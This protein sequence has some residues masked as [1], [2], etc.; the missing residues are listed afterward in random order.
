MQC[1]AAIAKL[2]DSRTVL[3]EYLTS[4]DG[5]K[6]WSKVQ[7]GHA[8]TKGCE[9]SNDKFSE[10]VFGT[11]DRMLKRNEN[12]SREAASGLAQAIRAKSFYTGDAV[13][14]FGFGL[15]YTARPLTSPT[16][17]NPA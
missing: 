12:I 3:P 10:S 16:P 5:A 6:C 13:V 2:H 17:P 14:P 15:S 4:Q 11:F 8:D 1:K 9:A 7:Q